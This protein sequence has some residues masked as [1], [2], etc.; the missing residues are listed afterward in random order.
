MKTFKIHFTINNTDDYFIVSGE[1]L[2]EIKKSVVEESLKRGLSQESNS[3][4]SEEIS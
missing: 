3:M 1:T 2:E 4:W